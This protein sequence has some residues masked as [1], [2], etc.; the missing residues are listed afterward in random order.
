MWVLEDHVD[1]HVLGDGTDD[2]E[3]RR[4]ASIITR[5]EVLAERNVHRN[6]WQGGSKVAR[7]L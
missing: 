7:T 6:S 2:S 4:I 5:K 1:S 3:V